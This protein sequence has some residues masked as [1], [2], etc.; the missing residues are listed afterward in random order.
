MLYPIK[1][2]FKDYPS[3]EWSDWSNYL[4]IAP[5]ISRKVESDNDGE[6]G[7]IAFDKA[8]VSFYYTEG[9]PVY[10]AFSIDLSSKQRY[11]FR[12]CA[13]KSDKTYVPLFEGIA[14]FSTIKW[15]E[16][17][18]EISFDIADK[19]TALGILPIGQT[20]RG[21][22]FDCLNLRNPDINPSGYT[23]FANIFSGAGSGGIYSQIG[24]DWRA[25]GNCGDES[26]IVTFLGNPEDQAYSVF[27]G[28]VPI[29]HT[30]P[31]LKQGETLVDLDGN[32]YLVLE[33]WN[34][35]VPASVAN[36]IGYYVDCTWVR[37][38]PNL[39][40]GRVMILDAGIT[41]TYH[42]TYYDKPEGYIDIISSAA[43]ANGLY[44]L[45]SF[46]GLKI[47]GTIFNSIWPDVSMTNL[48]GYSVFPLPA[49]Y[50]NRL[51]DEDPL[52]TDPLSA[53]KMLADT[54]KCYI[55]INRSGN[56]VIQ[57]KDYL[58]A[59]GT[60][61]TFGKTKIISKEKK[62]FWDK[63]ADG[64]TVN[65]KSWLKDS[66][67]NYLEGVS[68]QTKQIPGSSAY[69]KPKNVITKDLLT[70]DPN[71]CTQALINN[72][73]AVEANSILNFYGQR[74]T[75]A[76]I[77]LHLD[78]NTIE[79]DLLDNI[80]D[81][82]VRYF[83]VSMEID[84]VE[85]TLTL[86]P[87]EVTGHDYDLRQIVVTSGTSP[88]STDSSVSSSSTTGS[89]GIISYGIVYPESYG[90]IGDGISDDTDA[91]K[92]ALNA[93]VGKT[94]IL[95]KPA[96]KIT[97][98]IIK[99]LGGN[100]I[101][102]TSNINSKICFTDTESTGNYYAPEGCIHFKNGTICIEGIAFQGTNSGVNPS[103]NFLSA[104][105]ITDSSIVSLKNIS[106]T[107][108]IY[109]GIHII[110]CDKLSVENSSVQHCGYAGLF[111]RGTYQVTIIGGNYSYC[112]F[113]PYADGYGITISGRFPYPYSLGIVRD[114]AN[115][116]ITGV[117]ANYNY[118]KGI[119]IH[120]GIGAA[121]TS[122]KI[123]GFGFGGIY[124]VNEG[125]ESGYEKVVKD[126][127]VTGNIIEN[128]LS[129]FSGLGI[130]DVQHPIAVGS[131]GS[132][133]DSGGTHIVEGNII[134]NVNTPHLRAP[135]IAY[136]NQ[137]GS[138]LKSVVIKNNVIQDFSSYYSGIM[139]LGIENNDIPPNTVDISDNKIT[140]ASTDG[141]YIS[142]GMDQVV[143]NNNIRGT[144]T[145]PLSYSGTCNPF[146]NL[147]NGD[148][149]VNKLVDLYNSKVRIR[150]NMIE[151]AGTNSN[152]EIS[153]N[154]AGYQS[155][156]NQYRDLTIY[157]GKGN[158][159]AKF[160]G[161]LK[162]TE[163]FG[164]LDV[165][166]DVHPAA[167]R[168]NDGT[169]GVSTTS[170]G[171]IFKNG[172]FTG[173]AVSVSWDNITSIPSRVGNYANSNINI[174]S[175]IIEEN[176]TNGNASVT[177]NYSG[178]NSGTTQFRDLEIYDGKGNGVAKF[179][180]SSKLT[181]LS[182]NLDVTSGDIHGNNYRS[183]DGSYGTST[184]VSGM[185]FK[186][187]LYISGSVSIDLSA[188][189]TAYWV[190]SNFVPVSRTVNGYALS[191]NISLSKSDIG[192]GN[193]P[194]T[195][196][197][198]PDN[199]SWTSSY[200]TVTDTEKSTWNG[201]QNTSTK[202]RSFVDSHISIASYSISGDGNITISPGLDV[203]GNIHPSGNYFSADNTAGSSAATGGLT[204]K[205]GLYVSGSLTTS[206]KSTTVAWRDLD[207]NTWTMSVSNG[208][209]TSLKK[210]GTEQ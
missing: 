9:N 127:T 22:Q 201:K 95:T 40:A 47:I 108:A 187:G 124:A 162:L 161:S 130:T 190:N 41:N 5:L 101:K 143:N 153:I 4:S 170:S 203:S 208:L 105:Q 195:D 186:N 99:D 51:I 23:L 75:A 63:L 181:S 126:V 50:F 32:Q 188:Y 163:L 168:S 73:A 54:M 174:R 184:T 39:P 86:V 61:R 57:S 125:G 104:L 110:N 133:A 13:P 169:Y 122:N 56:L 148:L 18:S 59:N 160:V 151:E 131:F 72:K 58:A 91:F 38:T 136:L 159:V 82:S 3:G 53:L 66:D 68:T 164:S 156:L 134:K 107:N 62:Y 14:D 121:V 116:F 27:W 146:G 102:I 114:N 2:E 43:D 141:I 205:N 204:F 210:N 76:E 175:N 154:Y 71:D 8:S 78:D 142:A 147:Y 6:A 34:A 128:D 120:G 64:V 20:Q 192:L 180:G 199:I 165:T 36:S 94:L 197:T 10:N 93:A 140:G 96:Y 132:P 16:L 21:A 144:F 202:L 67:G 87:V 167:Y 79:W 83:Y 60:S 74:R 52:G 157:D 92:L 70:G 25:F 33:S 193:V 103:T 178:Y 89:M 207:A 123:K 24:H 152:S 183:S 119:D 137:S 158:G 129:W 194:N 112:G 11:L 177:I 81:D 45:E 98:K 26:I 37:L 176:A 118:R 173:G 111:V 55:Y 209:V 196:A 15:P 206:G 90:A 113:T 200:R 109:S 31:C 185:V 69:I 29:N 135:I 155:G 139:V 28:G 172:L 198:N 17:S 97:S 48:T 182:G 35:Q 145:Y 1:I 191:S 80:L 166:G 7:V 115:I 106:V 88:S 19:L 42:S 189:A 65:V 100:D 30:N 179:T 171:L 150:E 117:T 149:V 12:I 77:M 138:P 49:G 84:L 44:P 46:D 85:R